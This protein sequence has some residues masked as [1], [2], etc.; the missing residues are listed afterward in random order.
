MKVHHGRAAEEP[1]VTQ[2]VHSR[3]TKTQE[4]RVTQPVL[5]WVTKTEGHQGCP[6]SSLLDDTS[7]VKKRRR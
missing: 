3:L 7:R 2:S 5:S 4:R 6:S 1:R